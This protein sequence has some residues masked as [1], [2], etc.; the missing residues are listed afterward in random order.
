MH[1]FLAVSMCHTMYTN[2]RPT[3]TTS[4]ISTHIH[5]FMCV[6]VVSVPFLLCYF[7]ERLSR[8]APKRQRLCA[9]YGRWRMYTVLYC[10]CK[11][12]GVLACVLYLL[13]NRRARAHS[14]YT[15]A[16]G[17]QLCWPARCSRPRMCGRLLA[18]LH[19]SVRVSPVV[20]R[21]FDTRWRLRCSRFSARA[22]VFWLR[23]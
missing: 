23:F 4:G 13:F 5:T 14:I 1:A 21:R 11:T 8:A 19:A 3:L 10:I 12:C 7:S 6:C 22:P 16:R 9:T 20:S 17:I 18:Q 15:H 2:I